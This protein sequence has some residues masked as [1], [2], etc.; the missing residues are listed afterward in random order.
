MMWHPQLQ[1]TVAKSR[2]L[3]VSIIDIK[4]DD[5]GFF[6]YS[7]FLFQYTS[8]FFLQCCDVLYQFK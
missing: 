3:F 6:T 1:S 5:V 4:L 2:F 7:L 8:F